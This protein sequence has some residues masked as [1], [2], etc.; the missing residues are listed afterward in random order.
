MI[1]LRQRRRMWKTSGR[2]EEFVQ[3]SPDSPPVTGSWAGES[4]GKPVENPAFGRRM[5]FAFSGQKPENK[6]DSHMLWDTTRQPEP[7][8]I[9]SLTY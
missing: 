3:K 2:I 7:L 6:N 5:G 1:D 9:C 8:D 4:A